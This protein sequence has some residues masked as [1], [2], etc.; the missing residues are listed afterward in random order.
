MLTAGFYSIAAISSKAVPLFILASFVCWPLQCLIST[1]PQ[2]GSA[3]HFFRLICSVVL[4]GGRNT[5]NIHHW[6]V[7]GVF[8]VSQPHCVYPAHSMCAFPVHT[9]Q[10]L[11]C[12]AWNCLRWALIY[13]CFPGLSHMGSGSMVLHKGAD[14]VGL[15]FCALPRPKHLT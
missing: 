9:L 11:G 8:T 1:L 13:M 7:C 12:S 14:L 3:G 2:G 4:W 5:A 6:H 10:A 15:A